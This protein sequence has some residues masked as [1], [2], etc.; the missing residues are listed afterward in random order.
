MPAIQ[1]SP[2]Q[3][4][5]VDALLGTSSHLALRAR[6][7]CGKT[8]TILRAVQAYLGEFPGAE[9][10]V[11]AYNAE[12]KEEVKSKLAALGVDWRACGAETT[13]G[14]GFGLLRFRFRLGRESVNKN[15]VRDIV[16]A[17][18]LKSEIC[19]EHGAAVCSLVSKAKLSGFGCFPD[20][21]LDD[22]DAWV[23]LARAYD[24]DDFEDEGD[25]RKVCAVARWVLERSNADVSQVDYDDMIYLPLLFNV[26]VK[27]QKDVVFVDEAQDLSRVRRELIKRFLK[28][29][30]GRAVIVGDDRQAIYAFSGADGESFDNFVRETGATVL[31]LDVTRRCP[32]AVVRLAQQYVPDFTAHPDA[33]EG[34]VGDLPAVPAGLGAGDAVLCRNTAPLVELAYGLIRRRVACRVE[35]REIGAGLV[36]LVRRWKVKTTDGLRTRLDAYLARELAK[37][38]AKG[39]EAKADAVRDKVESLKFIVAECER[40]KKTSVEDV[41][42]FIEGL[43]GDR[44]EGCVVL[45]TYHRSK[46]RE[47][48]RVYLLEHAARCPSKHAK[49]PAQRA[50]E[51]NL[52]YVAYTRAMEELHF[53]PAVFWDELE[54]RRAA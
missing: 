18:E 11:A 27:F 12:I 26:R 22:A 29:G 31:P 6:A 49:K 7:G 19:R 1:L 14:L 47:W 13:H 34:T 37:A 41:V 10:L 24:L 45:A 16:R 35:G 8:F 4:A 21:R 17:Q 32:K 48:R 52:A 39:D 30:T 33:P 28:P 5:F 40:E 44:V 43:F 42:A 15:K 46:G 36:N 3:S 50:Q 38:A 20:L 54:G 9:L 25:L 53:V 23:E 2:Q 51:E